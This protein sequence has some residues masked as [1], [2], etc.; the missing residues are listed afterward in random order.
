MVS[1]LNE[2]ESETLAESELEAAFAGESESGELF[3]D[4]LSDWAGRQWSAVQTPGTWQRK[5]ALAA[6]K[7]AMPAAGSWL[8]GEL[9]GLAGPEG[10]VVG[11]I[12][13]TAL[14]TAGTSLLPSQESEGEFEAEGE[15]EIS[16]VRKVYLDAMMEHLAHEAAHAESEEEAA[17]EFLPLVPMLAGKLLP[18]AAKA[19]P[20]IA[21]R[22]FPRIARVVTR[23][24]PH[25]SR[26]VSNIARTL[27]RNQQ[28]RPLIRTVPTIARRAVATLARQAAAGRPV[29]PAG[30]QRI[31]AQHAYRVL[32][33]PQETV[34]VL[35]RNNIMDNRYHGTTRTRIIHGSPGTRIIQPRGMRY[36]PTCGTP[37]MS[38]ATRSCCCCN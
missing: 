1:A 27:Y 16:P 34:R 14:G 36:C 2:Y 24:T 9:G 38:R 10:A 30:A 4:G 22:V 3:L 5:A 26:G 13:G 17:E 7:S 35:R 28:T 15:Y 33:R 8:G 11:K 31:L 6:A 19:L 20:K 32:S 23:T 18:L 29:T 37:A 25:L 21:G 12:A